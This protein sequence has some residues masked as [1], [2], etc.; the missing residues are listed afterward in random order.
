MH[1]PVGTSFERVGQLAL[2]GQG[3]VRHREGMSA[4][5]SAERCAQ[6]EVLVTE[7]L[8]HAGTP[9][10]VD[11]ADAPRGV[12]IKHRV[13]GLLVDE[14]HARTVDAVAVL[15]GIERTFGSTLEAASVDDVH[16]FAHVGIDIRTSADGRTHVGLERCGGVPVILQA[17][18]LVVVARPVEA[19]R[20]REVFRLYRDKVGTDLDALVLYLAG[21]NLH[22]RSTRNLVQCDGDDLVGRA[23]L[24]EGHVEGD[25]L[26][27]ETHLEAGLPALDVLGLDE[28]VGDSARQGIAARIVGG[29]VVL[30]ERVG[31]GVITHVR[32]RQTQLHEVHHR[33]VVAEVEHVAQQDTSRHRR[34][35]VGAV[36]ARQRARP[37]VA[38]GDVQVVGVVPAERRHAVEAVDGLLG[39]V[40][41]DFRLRVRGDVAQVVHALHIEFFEGDAVVVVLAV[42]PVAA[43]SDGVAEALVEGV[44]R[45]AEQEVDVRLIAA[46]VLFAVEAVLPLGVLR[47]ALRAELIREVHAAAQVERQSGQQVGGDA[48]VTEK[49]VLVHPVESLIKRTVGVPRAVA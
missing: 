36:A 15:V 32:P 48:Q 23:R 22:A 27:E 3:E 2:I 42:H 29:G 10:G 39:A 8:R 17:D 16:L 13:T 4:I 31:T 20:P 24:V 12:V 28:R 43:E 26:L 25:A 5:L 19:E 6:G 45:V 30:V 47:T 49:A 7:A 38:S 41:I 33:Q 9:V 34:I 18:E 1:E 46:Q 11:L 40:R 21:V 14:H 37:V 35:E 44:A